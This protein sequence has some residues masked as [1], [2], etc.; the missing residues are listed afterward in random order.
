MKKLLLLLTL[1]VALIPAFAKPDITKVNFPSE[2]DVFGMFEI[3]FAMGSY[4]NPY[5]P[6]VI[7]VYAE[8]IGPD[9][10]SF[11]VDGFY[12]EGYRFK[13][14]KNIE[15][16]VPERASNGWRIRFTP[17]AV[18][19]W[20][21]ILHAVDRNGDITLKNYQRRSFAFQC[22]AVDSA[23]GFIKKANTKFLKRD[24]ID[25]GQHQERAFFPTGPNVAWYS[26]ADYNIYLKPYGI[27]GYEQYIDALAGNANYFRM[28]INRYQ[29]LSIYGPEN[30]E[31]VNG[32]PRMY[33]DATLN[34]KD[35]A[36]LDYIVEYAKSNGITI[37]PCIFN[38]RNY[39]HKKDVPTG[40]ASNPAMPSDWLNNPFHTVLG[41]ESP[42]Q[43]FTDPEAKRVSRQLLRYI[44]SR[45]GY[46]TNIL[47]WEL[48]NEVTNITEDDGMDEQTQLE[49][50][51]WH[52]E[53]ATYIR[54]VDPYRHLISTSLGKVKGMKT[55]YSK[56]F[57]TLDVVQNHNYQN[58][59][60]YNPI[61][62]FTY[63][64]FN[65]SREARLLYRYKPFFMGEYGFGQENPNRQYE[66]KDPLGVD[67]HN[68]LWSSAFSCSMGPASFWYWG[69]LKKLD[70]FRRYQPLLTFFSR[71]PVLSDS[72]T[73]QTT[74][75]LI[76]D[77]LVF[78]NELETYYMIN[79]TEDTI[80]GWSQDAAFGYQSLRYL[81]DP[82]GK[83][84]HFVDGQVNDPKGYVYTL[85]PAKR[86]RPSSSDNTIMIPIRNYKA[87]TR[88]TIHWF[89]SE[90][91]LEI[92]RE[93]TT[94]I[95]NRNWL[96]QR[97]LSFEFPSSIRDLKRSSINNTFGDAVFMIVKEP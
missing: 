67:M 52:D 68:S 29:Y 30:T 5:D 18:G 89:D 7:R 10:Q 66:D 44:V 37:M 3:S 9:N 51:D 87:G 24:V 48:W 79:A 28:W 27:Y 82:L 84:R 41:L 38:F 91:G 96:R 6:E 78:P 20:F 49:I 80:Y 54:S 8:F 90:T 45:W 21:F 46:S 63:L 40:T 25:K 95:V 33:F 50:A 86:P 59:Q 14:E 83:N 81:T 12:Y 32:K 39:I 11:T 31:R 70:L 34:Q 77:A 22:Q 73:P 56:V 75:Q 17:N 15:I 47:C 64:L 69:V 36:E 88:Y 53:M 93:A 55:L 1:L 35:S 92:A 94:A 76:G 43:F 26:S 60:K 71:L 13:K 4:A 72:F 42:Y 85:D 65:A 58:I 23:Q 19:Q 62:Q 57:T 61:E 97:R 16:A 2:V 74:G